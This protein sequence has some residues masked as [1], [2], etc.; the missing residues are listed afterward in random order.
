MQE[1]FCRTFGW[2]SQ[3]TWHPQHHVTA[4]GRFRQPNA[5][6]P[7]FRIASLGMQRGTGRPRFNE[8]MVPK[9]HFF[10]NASRLARERSS[11][12][13]AI[14]NSTS[15]LNV[16]N[17]GSA[18]AGTSDGLLTL[19]TKVPPATVV[20]GKI[21]G[22]RLDG[23]KNSLDLRPGTSVSNGGVERFEWE[24]NVH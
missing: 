4:P 14:R 8:R 9:P 2:Q 5:E 6:Q 17:N 3:T 11:G 13:M 15:A 18:S 16:R 12:V 21:G 23:L 10:P 22:F 7:S 20:L 24:L 1:R 19:T